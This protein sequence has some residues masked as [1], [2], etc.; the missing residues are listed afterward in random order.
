MAK[1]FK[2]GEVRNK[3]DIKQFLELPVSI[4]KGDKNWIRPIDKDIEKIFNPATNKFFRNGDAIR[5]ILS[6]NNGKVVV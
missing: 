4:N 3:E 6:D 5:W 2:L 1:N